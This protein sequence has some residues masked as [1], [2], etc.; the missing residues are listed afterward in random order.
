MTEKQQNVSSTFVFGPIKLA[1]LFQKMESTSRSDRHG[2]EG[3]VTYSAGKSDF[4]VNYTR[5]RNGGAT[6]AGTIE[7]E[8]KGLGVG[9]DYKFSKRS[10]FMMRY[11]NIKNNSTSNRGQAAYDLPT[12]ANDQDPKG[13]GMGIRHTF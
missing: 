4:M 1:L 13:F 10:T 3:A 7:P 9:W 11:A 8:A 12:L 2:S 6:T 5:E